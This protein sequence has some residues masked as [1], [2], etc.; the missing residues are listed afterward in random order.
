MIYHIFSSTKQ[1]KTIT[2]CF[3][4]FKIYSESI[5]KLICDTGRL[6]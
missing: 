5:K 4:D 1:N 3:C 2:D 6:I